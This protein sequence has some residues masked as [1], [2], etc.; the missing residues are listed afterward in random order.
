MGALI[1]R[2]AETRGVDAKALCHDTGFDLS[3]AQDPDARIDLKLETLLWDEAARRCG[4]PWFGISTADVI[5]I[6]D[7]DVL[8][9]VVRSAPTLAE[10]LSRLARYNRLVHDAA[11]FEIL[12]GQQGLR[13]EHRLP[14]HLHQSRHAAEFTIASLAVVG[15]QLLERGM[16]VLCVGFRHPK[17]DAPTAGLA[18]HRVFGRL[19]DFD[20]ESNHL[21]IPTELAALPLPAADPALFRVVQR[22]AEALLAKRPAPAASTTQRVRA[23]L[24]ESLAN[25]PS[26]VKLSSVAERLKVSERSL[27]RRLA[28]ERSSF[29]AI[30]EQ[31]RRELAERYL[32]DPR[33][34]ISEIGYLLG[35]SEASAFHRAFR[36]WTGMTPSAMRAQ[37]VVS[38][39]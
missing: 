27:Q 9:Y 4:D 32:E 22:H 14:A 12:R 36:R 26:E 23:L 8:D 33:L 31:L 2:S 34:G 29:D 17:P 13:I 39:K 37:R 28:D 6:G 11:S 21:E 3:G 25:D 15:R 7:F 18:Y 19:P 30:L 38:A 1:V 10:S 35:Y 5:R 20:C 24:A 16:P